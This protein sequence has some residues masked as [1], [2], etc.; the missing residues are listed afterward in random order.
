MQ[1]AQFL[2]RL[3]TNFCHV[4]PRNLIPIFLA[5]Y[6]KSD[7]HTCRFTNRPFLTPVQLPCGHT[8]NLSAIAQIQSK[9]LLDGRSFKEEEMVFDQKR[10]ETTVKEYQASVAEYRSST[11]KMDARVVELHLDDRGSELSHYST[12]FDKEGVI[13]FLEKDTLARR[14]AAIAREIGFKF[15]EHFE[16][17][18][19]LVLGKRK[20]LDC[21]I[22]ELC[23]GNKGIPR[24]YL[25][26]YFN[27]HKKFASAQ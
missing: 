23:E 21:K 11:A 20:R 26:G 19:L 5:R 18:G 22:S 17:Y 2:D 16:I 8:Y 10:F 27:P 9:C 15:N 25:E 1:R 3:N 12:L 14:M 13:L 7:I 4:I 24:V 6:W